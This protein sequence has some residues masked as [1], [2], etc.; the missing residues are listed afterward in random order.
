MLMAGLA[1]DA[2]ELC[3][4][5]LEQYPDYPAA[6]SVLSR[7]Y[8][9]IGD[10]EESEKIYSEARKRFSGN[11][12]VMPKPGEFDKSEENKS[13]H[14]QSG[15]DEI[16]EMINTYSETDTEEAYYEE[17]ESA[18]PIPEEEYGDLLE[19]YIEKD[20]VLEEAYHTEEPI[21][22]DEDVEIYSDYPDE[23]ES[24]PPESE[25]AIEESGSEPSEPGSGTPEKNGRRLMD[26]F[27]KQPSPDKPSLRAADP[28]II[29]GL[30]FLPSDTASRRRSRSHYR[31][32]PGPPEPGFEQPPSGRYTSPFS[33]AA[34]DLDLDALASRLKNAR[35][36]RVEEDRNDDPPSDNEG[37]M[38]SVVTETFAN[39][40]FNQGQIE[41]AIEA[42]E[43]L[44]EQ[45]P[46]KSDH[47]AERI[48][49]LQSRM[50]E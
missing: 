38:P 19:E 2:I 3:R 31:P 33:N 17:E 6:L 42:F 40:L 29:P 32:L 50:A 11:R 25:N 8:R 7:A 13:S 16:D 15:Q 10:S 27:I 36:E 49:D 23:F 5:G 4:R 26:S 1:E 39:I 35:I 14:D 41:K 22:E 18:E 12:S 46:E 43:K 45:H 20:T 47:Y 44:T 28:D 30:S 9:Q 24:E 21:K 37:A 48:A 34:D